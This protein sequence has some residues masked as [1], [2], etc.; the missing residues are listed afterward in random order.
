MTLAQFASVLRFLG[1][2]PIR[3]VAAHVEGST[4]LDL[5]RPRGPVPELLR[6]AQLRFEH[7]F[8]VEG[9]GESFL[10]ALDQERHE[11]PKS[12]LRS[13]DVAV[14]RVAL[15]HLPRL[16][17][18]VGSAHRLLLDLDAAE[19]WM[20]L[21]LHQAAR[22]KN[23]VCL[24]N[25]FRRYSYLRNEQ[26]ETE[27]ALAAAEKGTQLLLRAGD[28]LGAAKGWVEQGIWLQFLG[29]NDEAIHLLAWALN[30]LP[31]SAKLYR[32][33]AHQTLARAYQVEGDLANATACILAAVEHGESLGAWDR[34]KLHWLAARIRADAGQHLEAAGTMWGVVD[35][36]MARHPG[37]AALAFCDL[38]GMQLHQGLY[39]EAHATARSTMALLEPLSNNPLVSNALGDLIR[40]SEEGL[41]L[42][43]V[44]SIAARIEEER[45]QRHR[46]RQLQLCS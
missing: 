15:A 9:L 29:R 32:C 24:G 16:C 13:T 25:L 35:V 2:D 5:D 37:E 21:G 20:Y 42:A 33:S 38:V 46:W 30:E 1:L 36:L 18:I 45:R 34:A 39:A 4:L 27:Q 19:H 8:P 22:A 17:G 10:D 3:S 40:S 44:E 11:D 12:M 14:R 6:V 7:G 26:T 28:E 31:E 23:W 41:T 43:R